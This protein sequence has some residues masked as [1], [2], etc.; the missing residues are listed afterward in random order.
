ML[1]KYIDNLI[2]N[3]PN[4]HITKLLDKT[5]DESNSINIINDIIDNFYD[6]DI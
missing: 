1:Q 3:I 4:Q 6:I 5:N 2:D